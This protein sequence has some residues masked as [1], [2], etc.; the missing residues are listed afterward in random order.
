MAEGDDA[1]TTFQECGV[2][3]SAESK[4][5]QF[6]LETGLTCFAC[7]ANG[8]ATE[9]EAEA[10]TSRVVF[11]VEGKPQPAGS[12]KAFAVRR[13]ESG[14][15]VNTGQV[16]V[17]DDNPHSKTWQAIV[18]NEARLAMHASALDPFDGPLGLSVLFTLRRPK[19][20]FGKKGLLPSARLWP[21]V[22]PDATKLLRGV[23]D[24]L[25]GIVWGDDA[26]VVE[27]SVSKRYGE[28]EGAQVVVWTV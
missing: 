16:T 19:G 28:R 23:E 6:L 24:A 18:A 21:T 11:F 12:K 13:K 7:G 27:Q 2:C 14:G 1:V 20:H 3:G 9:V 26:Q 25:T 8:E 15:W 5:S 4:A 17:V 10:V 22:K